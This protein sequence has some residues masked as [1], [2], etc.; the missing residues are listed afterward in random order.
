MK[1]KSI[2]RAIV[3]S[4]VVE[5]IILAVLWFMNRRKQKG[6]DCHGE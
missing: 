2:I 4:I 1:R 3:A 5:V 6:G